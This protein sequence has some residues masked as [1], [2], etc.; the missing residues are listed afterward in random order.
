MDG[1]SKTDDIKK[2]TCRYDYRRDYFTIL[3]VPPIFRL[4]TGE[5]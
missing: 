5:E 3:W 1:S 4:K 2:D